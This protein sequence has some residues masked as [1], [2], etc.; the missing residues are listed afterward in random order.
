MNKIITMSN[1]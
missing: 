1:K